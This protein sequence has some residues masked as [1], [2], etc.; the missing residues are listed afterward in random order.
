VIL[1]F[2]AS[3]RLRPGVMRA[4]HGLQPIDSEVCVHLRR[5]NVGMAQHH[6]GFPGTISLRPSTFIAA[7]GDWT[8][9]LALHGF[10]KIFFLNG[11]GGNAPAGAVAQEWMMD[12]PDA[13]VR[14]HDWWRAPLTSAAVRAVDPKTGTVRWEFKEHADAWAGVAS[15]GASSP[16]AAAAVP[17][18]SSRLS[19]SRARSMARRISQRRVPST[20]SSYISWLSTSR[21]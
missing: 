5:R 9:S 13:H 6:L 4:M 19:V 11:H 20:G 2:R 16:R 12:N 17:G 21:S 7:I 15:A 14:F 1:S 18:T 8:R 3:P 10:E